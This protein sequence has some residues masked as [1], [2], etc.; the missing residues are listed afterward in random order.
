MRKRLREIWETIRKEEVRRFNILIGGL[1]LILPFFQLLALGF[2]AKK[3]ENLIALNMKP[4][5]WDE[6]WK[7][8]LV[9][10]FYTLVLVIVYFFVPVILMMLSGFFTTVLSKGKIFSLF[11][12]RGQFISMLMTFFFLVAFFLFPFAFA[13]AVAGKDFRKGF[14]I[15]EILAKIFLV[16]VEYLKAF[17]VI[18]VLFTVSLTVIFLFLNWVAACLI[19]GFILFFDSLVAIHLISKI[20]PRNEVSIR[21]P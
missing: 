19:A 15:Q 7:E 21:I 1:F 18:L 2:L 17:G 3:L 11:F 9:K 10:G 8:L 20:Y 12:F 5:Q 14:N 4:P 16:P 13:E 6:N